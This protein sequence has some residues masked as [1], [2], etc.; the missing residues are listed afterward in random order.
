M[1]LDHRKSVS[2]RLAQ[3]ARAYRSRIG[4]E[5]AGVG[6]HAGQ[7]NV[8]KALSEEDGQSMSQLATALAVQ[9]PTITK[10]VN[11]LAAQGYLERRASKGDARQAH[12]HLTNRGRNILAAVD[13]ALSQV[14]REAL[15]GIDDKDRRKIRRLLRRI[16]DNLGGADGEDE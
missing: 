14:E 4:A 1:S 8:L 13:K 11:R 7:E 5:L 6:L 15:S 12:V 10:M 2:V 9:P 16:E 3:A